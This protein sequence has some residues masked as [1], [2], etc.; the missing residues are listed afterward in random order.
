MVTGSCAAWDKYKSTRNKVNIAQRQAKT[1][2]FRTKI[3]NQNNNPKEVY[4][5][6]YFADIGPNLAGSIDATDI[7]FDR[8][9]KPATDI[10]N[11]TL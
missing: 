10:K 9:V 6:T 3:S 7:T 1:D 5:N 11:D 8:F 4:F 2:Y